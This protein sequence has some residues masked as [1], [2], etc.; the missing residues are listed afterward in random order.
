M[1]G[2]VDRGAPGARRLRG[3]V[4]AALTA[5]LTAVGHLAGGGSLPD[6]G[7]LA[8]L[9]PALAWPLIAIAERCRGLLATTAVLGAG[10]LVLHELLTTV[11][12]HHGPTHAAVTDDTS[13]VA[14]HAAVT[15]LTV[16]GLRYADQG[17]AALG[18]ALHRVVPRRPS[19]LPVAAG[20]LAVPV[21][22]DPAVPARTGRLLAATHV[23]RGPPVCC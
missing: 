23:R 7:L 13:M 12:T 4:L 15:A 16:L 17:I 9:L 21:L 22:P 2:S 11:H 18:A 14:V 8:V 5:L 3:T 20:P 19:P 6:L 1:D 10:Q